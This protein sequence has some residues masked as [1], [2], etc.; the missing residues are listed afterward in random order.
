M[1][2]QVTEETGAAGLCGQGQAQNY[3]KGKGGHNSII[4]HSRRAS[5]FP[6]L[7]HKDPGVSVT[8]CKQGMYYNP[9]FIGE[10]TPHMKVKLLVPDRHS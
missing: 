1:P 10:E 2:P 7:R 5:C 4:L 8:S 3:S 6:K 9:L